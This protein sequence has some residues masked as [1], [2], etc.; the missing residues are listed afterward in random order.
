MDGSSV[1]GRADRKYPWNC[2]SLELK[3]S[4]TKTLLPGGACRSSWPGLATNSPGSFRKKLGSGK[5][6]I[7]LLSALSSVTRSM[8]LT[9]QPC[10]ALS[11]FVSCCGQTETCNLQ[12]ST[13]N[14]MKFQISGAPSCA[15]SYRKETTRVIKA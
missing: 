14:R 1:R 11:D 2:G 5:G 10:A 4:I 8:L 9:E 12:P 3:T 15:G 7:L 13:C 6:E